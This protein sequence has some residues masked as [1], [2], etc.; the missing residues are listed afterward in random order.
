MVRRLEAL[1]PSRIRSGDWEEIHRMKKLLGVLCV[2][3]LA[4]SMFGCGEEPAKKDDK[5]PKPPVE[6]PVKPK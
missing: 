1:A 5:K 4:L 2:G 3:V 6:K